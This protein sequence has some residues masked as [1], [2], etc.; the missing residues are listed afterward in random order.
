MS[1]PK[2]EARALR[3]RRLALSEVD[4]QACALLRKLADEAERGVLCTADLTPQS[5]ERGRG[6]ADDR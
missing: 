2:N 6:A 4:P 5:T 1:N 3:Y